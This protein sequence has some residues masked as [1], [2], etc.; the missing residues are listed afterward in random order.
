[1]DLLGSGC[2][3]EFMASKTEGQRL[4]VIRNGTMEKTDTDAGRLV[5]PRRLRL[6]LPG[7]PLRAGLRL[8][9]RDVPPVWFPIQ[10]NLAAASD[11]WQAQARRVEAAL[12][13]IMLV[14]T[15]TLAVRPLLNTPVDVKC[16]RLSWLPGAKSVVLSG[17][18]L[19]LDSAI[20]DPERRIRTETSLSSRFQYPTI[21]F[22][23]SPPA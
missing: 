13:R 9:V 4:F 17:A 23:R 19:P 10:S 18:F 2:K 6:P 20:D 8:A 21:E 14:D 22:K 7:R 5:Q 11:S 15:N 16:D 12:E 3:E 1:M